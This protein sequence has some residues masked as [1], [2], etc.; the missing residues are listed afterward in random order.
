MSSLRR[1]ALTS[2]GAVAIAAVA[3]GCARA[4]TPSDGGQVSIPRSSVEQ[5]ADV[6]NRAHTNVEI[7]VP[8]QVGTAT[9]PA[10]PPA[11]PGDARNPKAGGSE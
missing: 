8:R 6:G 5:P 11:P 1:M 4:Q 3:A 2:V 9:Q 7:F 10:S